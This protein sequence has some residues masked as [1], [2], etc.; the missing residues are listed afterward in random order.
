VR[1]GGTVQEQVGAVSLSSDEAALLVI[2]GARAAVGRIAAQELVVFDE[3]AGRW[4]AGRED[5]RWSAPGSSVGFGVDE[6]LISAVAI[7]A[8]S[9]AV[10]EVLIRGA[11]GVKARWWRRRSR[12]VKAELPAGP[13]PVVALSEEQSQLL[14][15][16]CARHAVVLG[17]SP[18]AAEL[19]ADAVIGRMS[20]AP[21]EP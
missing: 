13:T 19:L 14:R 3:I 10:G 1:E 16:A 5:R 6:A 18:E 8:V 11:D 9:A 7:Q 2:D 21:D 17:L 20:T 4:W 12:P 15:E